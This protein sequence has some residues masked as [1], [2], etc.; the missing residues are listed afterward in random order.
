MIVEF[1][2]WQASV[3]ASVPSSKD[4]IDMGPSASSD[5]SLD[6][7]PRP[8]HAFIKDLPVSESRSDSTFTFTASVSRKRNGAFL[9]PKHLHYNQ[10][11]VI[12]ATLDKDANY[13]EGLM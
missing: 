4:T 1:T 2:E 8:P 7:Q 12:E 3:S 13:V 11:H 9:S 5:T 6:I 10:Q